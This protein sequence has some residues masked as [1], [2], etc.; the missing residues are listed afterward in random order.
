M[1]K[2]TGGGAGAKSVVVDGNKIQM[3]LPF[4]K[5]DKEKRLVSGF[6]TL[7]NIDTQGDVVLADASADAFKR[8]RGNI[9]EMHQPIAAGKMVDFREEELYHEGKMYRGIFVTVQV[10]K[11][12]ESTWEKVL[13]GTLTG[14]SIGGEINEIENKFVK[15]A[16]GGQG[17]TVRFIKS[18]D[19]E[20]LSLVDNPANQ[21]ANVLSIEKSAGSIRVE[22]GEAI[23]STVENV[24]VC[25]SCD[26]DVIVVRDENALTCPNCG[27][28]M[29]NAGWIEDAGDR[30]ERVDAVVQKFRGIVQEVEPAAEGGVDMGIKKTFRKSVSDEENAEPVAEVEETE[31]ETETDAADESAEE[32]EETPEE[33]DEV[34]ESPDE[35]EDESEAISK[36][37]DELQETVTG[38]IKESKSETLEKVA[39]LE[40]ALDSTKNEF[41]EKT[42]ELASKIESFGEK[43]EAQKMRINELQDNLKKFNDSSAFRKSAGVQ[44][45]VA[46]ND[47]QED[48]FWRGAFSGR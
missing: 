25:I 42:S 4:S 41:N 7:D 20:E 10:S 1:L 22:T 32:V 35:V 27:E 33:E 18:Y 3:S 6:A 47:V 9:R 44:E 11:G 40:K 29:Q 21:L 34:E 46:D 19:L 5:V 26:D 15:D 16:N 30:A 28:A 17:G 36:K 24:F 45:T 43:I 37:I 8:A 2:F 14:F 12:A 13:D 48:E 31:E 39:A 38:A 23:D